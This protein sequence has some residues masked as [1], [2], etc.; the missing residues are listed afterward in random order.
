MKKQK[1]INMIIDMHCHILPKVDDGA[2]SLEESMEMLRLAACE[3]IVKVI[4]TPHFKA[5]KH[6][7]SPD[8]IGRRIQEL[9][10]IVDEEHLGIEILPGNE[11]LYFNDLLEEL[12]AKHVLTLAGS[13]YVLV[14]FMPGDSYS[15]IRNAVDELVGSGYVP[16]IAHVERYECLLKDSKLAD[17]LKMLGAR[18]QIN[19]S[20]IAGKHGWKIKRYVCQ[21]LKE[22]L[23]DY[24]GT[25]AH[26][27]KSRKPEMSSCVA[28]LL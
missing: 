24:I 17:E 18:I 26:D 12:E 27:M 8:G 23:V 4:V 3:G 13:N 22:Q 14:E 15:R 28:V 9:Q 5:G 20:S 19:A 2:S 7:A 16:V 1:D 10:Q 11:I 6:N 25:D 21:L